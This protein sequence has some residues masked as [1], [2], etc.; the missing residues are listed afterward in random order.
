MFPFL[1]SFFLLLGF[2]TA[3][4]PRK[5]FLAAVALALVFPFSN[6]FASWHYANGVMA[7]DGF[8]LGL[9]PYFL[10]ILRKES[11]V[12]NKHLLYLLV[13]SLVLFAV[14]FIVALDAG[15]PMENLLKDLRPLLHIVELFMLFLL[16]KNSLFKIHWKVIQRLAF[17]ASASN[18]LWFLLG[19]TAFFQFE[20]L[21]AQNNANRYLDLS[22]YFSLYFLL[23]YQYLRA[24]EQVLPGASRW[25]F[26]LSVISVLL[27]NSR[28]LF[29]ATLI[30]IGILRTTNFK[31]RFKFL[32]WGACLVLIFIQFS[33]FIGQQRVL[34]SIS[35]DSFTTQL[36]ERFS[37]A[38]VLISQMSFREMIFGYG[39]GVYF[40][41]PWFEYRGLNLMN[42]SV[43]SAYLTHFV[44]QG[45]FGVLFL[46]GC[47]RYL[48]Y[49]EIRKLRLVFSVF[50][51]IQ[52][53]V[54]AS[55]F[56]NIIYGAGFYLFL[57][58]KLEDS[59]YVGESN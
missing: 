9:I 35:S 19:F 18:I 24:K 11:L 8:F 2:L 6:F 4:D 49:C 47:I 43:D 59:E 26:V 44:K 46:L 20:D 36:L 15:K 29:L 38:L 12:V 52:F 16:A 31:N 56:Q 37:P 55:L 51:L 5:Y 10:F 39:L 42:V 53:L 23:H 17:L 7:L 34:D 48:A 32:F 1:F 58:I 50:W 30:G 13:F 28:V 41:I 27:T 3:F 54:E 40:E 57:L 14:Y 22:T 21:Y 25:I 45:L 33:L